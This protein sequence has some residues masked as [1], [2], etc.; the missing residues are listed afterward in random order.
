MEDGEGVVIVDAGGGTIDIS[1][2]SKNIGEGT[3]RFEEV[4]APQCNICFL[5]FH[6]S[7][8]IITHR[9]FSWFGLCDHA[10][11]TILGGC[12]LCSSKCL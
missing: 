10:R 6:A 9:P 12:V 8:L 4:A 11:S 3:A 2:Y 5:N 7:N 1:S